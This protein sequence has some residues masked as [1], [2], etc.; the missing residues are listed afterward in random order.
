MELR[1]LTVSMA[2]ALSD[3]SHVGLAT[4]EL[5]QFLISQ[6]LMVGDE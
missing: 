1:A 3:R 2:K 6:E 4:R 5:R